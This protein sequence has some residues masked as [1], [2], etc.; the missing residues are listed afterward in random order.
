M[1]FARS[2]TP[3]IALA[4]P[5]NVVAFLITRRLLSVFGLRYFVRLQAYLSQAMLLALLIIVAILSLTLTEKSPNA[6]PATVGVASVALFLLTLLSFFL[7]SMLI[8]GARANRSCLEHAALLASRL[9]EVRQ[10]AISARAAGNAAA[11]DTFT[12]TGLLIE[13]AVNVVRADAELEPLKILSVPAT[14]RLIQVIAISIVSALGAGF[15]LLWGLV[16]NKG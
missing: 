7:M 2:G 15:N 9:F 10:L 13:S 1:L 11:A 14:F 8:W 4:E 16:L 6:M 3:V 5:G 12:E